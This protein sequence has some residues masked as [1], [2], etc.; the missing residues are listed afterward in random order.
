MGN[1]KD[2]RMNISGGVYS[3]SKNVQRLREHKACGNFKL[4]LARV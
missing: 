1:G 3:I 4:S 2:F